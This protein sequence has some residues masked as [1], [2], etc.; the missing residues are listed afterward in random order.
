SASSG[1]TQSCSTVSA[2]SKRGSAPSG[3]TPT[4]KCAEKRF[5]SADGVIQCAKGTSD[6]ASRRTFASSESSRA[7]V[8]RR[9]SSPSRAPPGKTKACAMKEAPRW[10]RSK[11][12][13]A[14]PSC[15]R[16]RRRITVAAS[17]GFT[18]GRFGSKSTVPLE[19]GELTIAGTMPAPIEPLRWEGEVP[20]TLWILDQRRL[21]HERL[22]LRTE[23]VADCADAIKTLAV[24]GAPAIGIAAAFGVVLGAQRAKGDTK[25]VLAA[26]DELARSRPTAKNLFWALERMKKLV[27]A[28]AEPR[29]LLDE[30]KTIHEEDRQMC[31]AIGRHG[32]AYI[33]HGANVLTHCNA[34]GLATG[35]YGTAIGCI[36][37]AVEAGK[38]VHVFADETRP[39]LQGARLTAFELKESGVPVTLLAD[40][41]A[42]FA[43]QRRKIDLVVVGADRICRNGDFANKIGTYSV[44]VLAKEHG[45]P[46]YV[47][48]P[49]STFD[50]ELPSGKEIPIEERSPDE[51]G[52]HAGKRVAP[53]GVSAW[54]PAFDVTP[55]R[56]VTAFFTERGV[57]EAPSE[58]RVLAHFG[59]RG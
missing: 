23:T 31:R 39:L 34:G 47:A 49:S 58:A 32:A 7:A 59:A 44:A 11:K 15:E 28:G 57:I 22:E 21:P 54:N 8:W 37:A 56:Y 35:A 13:S 27:L 5:F 16:A 19:G 55:A 43:M 30:A 40:N 36:Y 45:I 50:L 33:E 12:T 48:A 51:V 29:R 53:E 4:K 9:S 2:P 25:A 41:M 17:R 52:S 24:R 14:A 20:G 1:V 3:S 42:G 18:V 6:A 26:I 38:K 46:F 10:R